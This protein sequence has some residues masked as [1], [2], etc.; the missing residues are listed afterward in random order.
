[1]CP[2]RSVL[3]AAAKLGLKSRL[4]PILRSW[5]FPEHKRERMASVL[6]V[7]DEPEIRSLLA[8]AVQDQG[9]TASV[10]SDGADALSLLDDGL[11][12]E[13]VITDLRMPRLSGVEL[14]AAIH[15]RSRPD[16]PPIV[17][18]SADHRWLDDVEGVVAKLP[19][20]FELREIT[21][22]VETYCE[23]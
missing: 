2:T 6:I 7:D 13:L 3:P 8:E 17:L 20:P 19:K 15:A 14:A 18:M 4:A 9:H 10:A 21:Q 16:V 22:L 5:P 1:M 12:P 11:R 23:A